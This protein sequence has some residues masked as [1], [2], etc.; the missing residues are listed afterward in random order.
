MDRSPQEI[1]EA[2]LGELQ[3]QVSKPNYRT[4]LEKTSGLNFQDRTFT[5]GVANAFAAEY[6]ERNQRSL[7]EKTLIGI[8]RHPVNVIF[9]VDGKKQGLKSLHDTALF[10]PRYNF[11]SFVEGD[12]NR[13]A[14]AAALNVT[15][16]PGKNYNPLFIY[17]GSGV[18][19]THL[20]QAIGQ[21]AREND[22]KVLYVS[23]EQFTNEFVNSLRERKIEEFNQKYR[24]AQM[25]LI[26]DVQFIGG[27]EQ[28]EECFFHTFNQLHNAN[29]QIALTGDK[30]PRDL[31]SLEDRLRSR[32]EWGLMVDI[33]PPD[34]TTRLAILQSKA[35]RENVE[36]PPEVLQLVAE[37]ARKNVRELEGLLNR[38]TAYAKLT[39]ATISIEMADRALEAVTAKS[40]LTTPEFPQIVAAV[41]EGFRLT[42]EDL[43]GRKRDKE[44]ALARQVAMYLL[45]KETHATLDDIGR[46]FDRNSS[47]VSHA[48]DKIDSAAEAPYLKHKLADI[49]RRL[50][51]PKK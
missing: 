19:K 21:K 12:C 13:L 25:L 24:S 15:E 1:W 16:A 5:V 44:T 9:S 46:Q 2:A 40:Q 23:G 7:I 20:L 3:L 6:L 8:V 48:Y 11:N 42:P 31:T 34:Y 10:N 26:D 27:K 51:P 38:V 35:T 33:Q 49:Q 30:P 22:L 39:R 43:L 36:V 18:G 17:G 14:R 28:T 29:C 32:L 41:A 45:K 50:N 47:T 37:Q 4:W